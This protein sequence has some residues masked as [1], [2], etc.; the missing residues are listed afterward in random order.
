[1]TCLMAENHG[2]RPLKIEENT[3][4][5]ARPTM[6]SAIL[7]AIPA[8]PCNQKNDMAGNIAPMANRPKEALAAVHGLPS[9]ASSCNARDKTEIQYDPINQLFIEDGTIQFVIHIVNEPLDIGSKVSAHMRCN[10]A[11]VSNSPERP[12]RDYR[13]RF[14][15]LAKKQTIQ[16]S[17]GGRGKSLPRSEFPRWAAATGVSRLGQPNLT[18]LMC[19]SCRV[20]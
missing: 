19:L 1:M 8:N 3:P 18:A 14:M 13:V 6:P 9:R 7:V 10:S 2:V 20:R 12:I 5:A 16:P 11:S 17:A 4:V 15:R